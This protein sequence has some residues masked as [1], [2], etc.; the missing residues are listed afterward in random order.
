MRISLFNNK[1]PKAIDQVCHME[2]D[3]N[4]P[5]GGSWVH[6]NV[7]Y[8]FCGLGCKRAFQKEPDVYLSGEKSLDMG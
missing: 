4:D 3:M 1:G 7:S 2:V 6:E 5:P 8:Y